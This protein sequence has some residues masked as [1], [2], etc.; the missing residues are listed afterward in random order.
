VW[1]VEGSGGERRANLFGIPVGVQRAEDPAV[2]AGD[3]ARLFEDSEQSV[4]K[5]KTDDGG[6]R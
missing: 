2:P 4:V 1:R 3:A 5:V 6:S